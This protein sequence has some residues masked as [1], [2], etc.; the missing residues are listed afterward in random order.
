MK[1]I[2]PVTK[3]SLS[4]LIRTKRLW[5]QNETNQQT[6]FEDKFQ[7]FRTPINELRSYI[8]LYLYIIYFYVAL[9]CKIHA[10]TEGGTL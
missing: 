10:E 5:K 4:P 9:W 2:C 8:L 3:E 6:P 7:K 1:E